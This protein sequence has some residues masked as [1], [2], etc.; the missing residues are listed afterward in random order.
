MDQHLTFEKHWKF[1]KVNISISIGIL[2]KGKNISVRN[3]YWLCA[4]LSYTHILHIVL[5]CG[6]LYFRIYLIHLWNYRRKLYALL[7]GRAGM[8]ILHRSLKKYELLNNK[9]LCIFLYNT[10][11]ICY[12]KNFLISSKWTML[13]TI[14]TQDKK[15]IFVCL[16]AN[17]RRSHNDWDALVLKLTTIWLN[18]S[19]IIFHMSLLNKLCVYIFFTYIRI[20]QNVKIVI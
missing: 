10:T 14:I 11:R 7:M 8:I 18:R 16:F 20:T 4:M 9:N 5:L 6:A 15:S 19:V 1:T 13:S 2:Y 17:R 3:R 12:Q